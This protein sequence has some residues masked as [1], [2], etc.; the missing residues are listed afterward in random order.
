VTVVLKARRQ[1]N[2]GR[3]TT[4]EEIEATKQSLLPDN[5]ISQLTFDQ[6]IDLV[7]F[8]RDVVLRSRCAECRWNYWSRDRSPRIE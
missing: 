7:A 5:V 1:G 8:R 3:D 6:F 2:P 4:V